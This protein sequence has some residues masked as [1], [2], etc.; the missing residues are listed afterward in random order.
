MVRVA[1][2]RPAG[3]FTLIPINPDQATASTAG[4]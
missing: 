3:G 1:G 4:G 2:Y